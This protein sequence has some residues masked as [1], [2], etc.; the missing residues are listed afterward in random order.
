MITREILQI[1]MEQ[2]AED[3]GCKAEDFLKSGNVIVP[4]RL[5]EKARKYLKEPIMANF[6]SYGSNV[7]AAVTEDVQE[8][9]TEYVGKY[10]FYH[11]FETPNM[12]WLSDRLAGSGYKICFMAEY[13]L[14]DTDRLRPLPCEYGM[15]ILGQQDFESLYLPE[16]GNA[17]CRDRKQLD[18]LG[19]G[20]YEGGKLV[21]LAG[22]S[23]DCE[24]MWQIG[25]DVLP[26]YRKKGIASALTGRLAAEILER[27]K[28]PFYCSAWS[29]VRSARN[30]VKSGF[31]PA[32]VEMTIKPEA[33]VKEMNGISEKDLL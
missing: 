8:P 2:S 29:N 9:V 13:F 15:R 14:P 33:V 24:G 27:G 4:F 23:A 26:E 12:H 32:W 31:V 1:A 3:I 6:V 17:L 5:G 7:V 22:C 20:A 16:W 19:V 28:V 25:V 21:G 11:L 10:E 30:A 18:I